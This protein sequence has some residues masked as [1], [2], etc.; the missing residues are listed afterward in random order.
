MENF[1]F[2]KYNEILGRG[3]CAGVGEPN[4]QM[5]IEAAISQA[6]GL[7]FNDEP[8]CVEPVIR[9]YKI[10]LNDKEWSS[11]EAR[12]KGM[13]D[14]GIAQLGSAGTVDPKA[15]VTRLA[16][17]HIRELVPAVFREVL[18]KHP[19]CME[20][21]DRCEKEGTREAAYAAY[22]A[23]N[24]Y[25]ADYAAA[26]AADY[27]YAADYASSAAD[28]ASSAADYAYAA[29]DYAYAASA[30]AYAHS[31][32]AY[33]QGKDKYLLLSATICLRVLRELNAPG[34]A[35]LDQLTGKG[36]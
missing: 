19:K 34:V 14:L 7:P 28:Y 18:S 23:A 11:P 29:A 8:S 13:Y 22:A 10:A 21:A 36:K 35:L 27:A 24:A 31:A 33:A 30:A 15:F 12:A 25:A 17:L 16:E 32:A 2:D 5:C 1:N 6:C 26:S 9:S 20:A 3:L 4:G